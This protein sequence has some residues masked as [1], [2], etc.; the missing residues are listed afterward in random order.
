MDA[1]ADGPLITEH[2]P[3]KCPCTWVHY[4]DDPRWYLPPENIHH[5]CFIHGKARE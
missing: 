4:K 1:Q 2:L 3:E 5:G